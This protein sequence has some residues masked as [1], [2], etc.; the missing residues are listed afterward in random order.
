MAPIDDIAKV[1]TEAL[2][3]AFR[4]RE[5]ELTR[6]AKAGG[7]E[8]GPGLFQD[9]GSLVG[10]ITDVIGAVPIVGQ[11]LDIPL[12]PIKAIEDAAGG[13]GKAFGIGFLLGQVGFQ[14]LDPLFQHVQHA[15]ADAVQSEI[16]DPQTAAMLQ[17]K[18]IIDDVYGRSEAAGGNLSGEHYDKLVDAAEQRPDVPQVLDAWLKGHVGEKDVDLALQRHGIPPFWW[19]AIKDLKR[20][21]LSP[22]DL[23]LSNLRGEID[24]TTMQG[25][26]NQLGVTPDDMQVLIGNTGEPPGIEQ[27]LFLWRRQ[28]ISKDELERA[29]KQSR[30]RNEWIPAVEALAHIPMSTSDAVRAVVE[31]HMAQDEGAKIADQNGLDADHY[32]ILVESWGRPLSHEQMLTLFHRGQAT[33]EQ[34]KQAMKESDIKNKYIDQAVELG[35][36]LVPERTIVSMLGHGVLD[37]PRALTM[38]L[39]QGFNTVD[40]ENLIALG[41][42]Q[43]LATHH[44]LTRADITAMYVDSLITRQQALDHLAKLSFDPTDSAAILDLADVKQRAAA[45]R[46]TQR[47][48]EAS[49]KAKHL[50]QQAAINALEKAGV[51]PA[52]ARALVDQ[53]LQQRGAVTKSLTE[54]QIIKLVESKLISPDDGLARLQGTGLSRDDAI[55]LL[56]LNGIVQ[57]AT[58]TVSPG[59]A[60]VGP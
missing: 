6:I 41:G 42:A 4:D 33:L 10:I 60:S 12:A 38:L 23:A 53:W 40:A 31:G 55:L 5:A 2:I 34:V 13:G 59:G 29:I 36:R 7:K 58:F 1:I 24:D 30:V 48:I 44:A 20:Q 18:G 26:A 45:L 51:E 52:Q 57:G 16:F 46:V 49:L 9:V 50:T 56:A 39:E 8:A 17:S 3:E 27:M 37:H 14:A 19:P 35:R 28:L 32:P 22:A 11:L 21:F 25:Y 15:V 54:A 47:G 43:H